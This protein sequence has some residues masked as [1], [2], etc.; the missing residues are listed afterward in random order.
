MGISDE[1]LS[2]AE[3]ISVMKS[4]GENGALCVRVEEGAGLS[5]LQGVVV[6]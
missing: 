5:W 4:G 1:K 2:D 6:C 3:S